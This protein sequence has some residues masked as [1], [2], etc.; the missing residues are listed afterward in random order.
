MSLD[1]LFS[2]IA[3]GKLAIQNRIVMPPMATNYTSPEGF[4]T[5]RQIAYYVERAKGDVGYITVEHTGI[6]QQGKASPKMLLIS[7][8]EHAAK[9]KQLVEAVHAAGGKIF[10]QINHVGRQTASAVTGSPVVGPSPIPSPPANEIIRN[11]KA[12]LVSMG[13]ALIA[14]P[15]LPNKAKEGR[16]Q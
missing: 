1:S 13:R 8:D 9:I 15:H 12:D 7:T 10:V 4:V 11:R 5:D 3:I 2:P 14:D 6:L 16:L